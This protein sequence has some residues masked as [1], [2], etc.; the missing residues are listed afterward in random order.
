[1]GQLEGPRAST[2]GWAG[3]VPPAQLRSS[4]T[5]RRED[6]SMS[7]TFC[8]PGGLLLICRSLVTESDRPAHLTPIAC[9]TYSNPNFTGVSFSEASPAPTSPYRLELNIIVV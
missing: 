2:G 6:V 5:E 4:S 7:Y 8:S 1:M 9:R 3:C